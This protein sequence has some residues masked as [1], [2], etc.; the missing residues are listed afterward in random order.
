MQ[1]DRIWR[2]PLAMRSR[3]QWRAA[4]RRW[5][6]CGLAGWQLRRG[7]LNHDDDLARGTSL[8]DQLHSGCRI[9]QWVGPVDHGSDTPGFDEFADLGEGL[10]GDLGGE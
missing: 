1:I 3:Q 8:L 2:S 6:I 4:F 10:G 7:W 5:D 9:G